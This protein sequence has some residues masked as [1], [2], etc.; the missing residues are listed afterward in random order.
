MIDNNSNFDGVSN[1]MN[2]EDEVQKT[3]TAAKVM[4]VVSFIIGFLMVAGV[5]YVVWLLLNHFGVLMAGV[6]L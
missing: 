6:P 1:D 4:L 2:I 3:M 5:S